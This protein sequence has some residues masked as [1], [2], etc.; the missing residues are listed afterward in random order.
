ISRS[1]VQFRLRPVHPL[2]GIGLS[3][4]SR[5]NKRSEPNPE[6]QTVVA[7]SPKLAVNQRSGGL[8]TLSVSLDSIPAACSRGRVEVFRWESDRRLPDDKT[9]VRLSYDLRDSTLPSGGIGSARECWLG[10]ASLD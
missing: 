9:T 8:F 5:S 2:P 6:N 4:I 3:S 7:K 1:A 10:V